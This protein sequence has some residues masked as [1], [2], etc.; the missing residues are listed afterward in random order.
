[1]TEQAIR[2]GSKLESL[3]NARMS[4]SPGADHLVGR[5]IPLGSREQ[6]RFTSAQR[7]AL[8]AVP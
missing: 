6:R 8:S 3:M 5:A 4:G 1:V 7:G 2:F